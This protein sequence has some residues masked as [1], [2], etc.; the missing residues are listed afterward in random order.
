MSHADVALADVPVV[1]ADVLG[2]TLVLVAELLGRRGHA[3]HEYVHVTGAAAEHPAG[4]VGPDLAHV[5]A[6]FGAPLNSIAVP[7]TSRRPPP[8][9]LL[10]LVTAIAPVALH[11][12]VPALPLLATVFDASPGAVQPVLTLFLTGIAAGQ[13]IYGPV[14]DR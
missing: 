12:L 6:P 11:I 3:G 4:R 8:L 14:S 7:P 2:K 13:L 10:A 5:A 9:L 1:G